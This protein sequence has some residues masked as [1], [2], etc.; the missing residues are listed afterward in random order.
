MHK[1]KRIMNWQPFV[2]NVYGTSDRLIPVTS[3]F[4][5]GVI[6]NKMFSLRHS[7]AGS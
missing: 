2:N 3:N 6:V 1:D 7:S 4:K 5:P